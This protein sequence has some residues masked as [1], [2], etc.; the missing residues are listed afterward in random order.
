MFACRWRCSLSSQKCPA[1]RE[2]PERIFLE[3][4]TYNHAQLS[5]MRLTILPD[6]QILRL[7]NDFTTKKI[8]EVITLV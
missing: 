2:V 5:S 1:E 3:T 7:E 4:S 8:T 6:I